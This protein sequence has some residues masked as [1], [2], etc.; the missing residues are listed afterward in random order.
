MKKLLLP[1]AALLL[2]STYAPALLLQDGRLAGRTVEDK[3][4]YDLGETMTFELKLENIAEL[5]D[6]CKI[7]WSCKGDDG[8]FQKGE[9]PASLTE[10]L[11][12]KTSLTKPGFV[13]VWAE[14]RDAEGKAVAYTEKQQW[15]GNKISFDGGAGVQIDTLQS[16]EEPAD[17][18]AFWAKQKARLAE[19]PVRAD[20][21]ELPCKNEKVALYAVSIDC[22]GPRPVTG[23]LSIPKDASKKY[24]ATVSFH[25][26]G[27]NEHKPG[28]WY[29]DSEIR[30]D[31]NAHGMELG[32]D[33]EYYKEF[34]E[35]IKSNGKSYAFDPVQNKD[36]ETAYFN[37]MALRVMRA[38]DYVKTLPEW[39]GATLR[40]VGGSQGGLQTSW[41]AGLVEG[42]TSA[43]PSIPWCCDM[44]GE[45]FGRMKA[46]WHIDY[47][48]SMNYYDPVHH[49]KRVPAS[50][51][52]SI[53]R[54]GLGDY[55][56]PPSGVAVFFNNIPGNK[57]ILWV[58]GS[59]HG[60]V[61]PEPRQEYRVK[62]D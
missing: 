56:C 39:D 22:A 46:P 52:V 3:M 31:I 26:Y 44:G 1:F 19:V 40:A 4:L 5:P 12:I 42:L 32:R 23:Y 57:E 33:A 35:S 30:L 43:E 59:T 50:C 10:P 25:G 49:A 61:P 60:Y 17:F 2:A 29:G 13:H 55:T 16:V 54:A 41:A 45:T 21:K 38:F 15:F 48:P 20:R 36:P 58:Q 53:P 37:G 51:R 18:D 14:L 11:V 7:V 28:G 34:G 6:G 9:V 47:Q 27:Y 62:K 24:Q 8:A